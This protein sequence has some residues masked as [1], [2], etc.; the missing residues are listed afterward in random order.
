M[1]NRE[2]EQNKPSVNPS[3]KTSNSSK[4]KTQILPMKSGAQIRATVS[5][6][7]IQTVK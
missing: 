3:P 6:Y 1:L 7:N 5:N 4:T 2:E